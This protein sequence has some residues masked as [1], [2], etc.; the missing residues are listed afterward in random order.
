MMTMGSL[1]MFAIKKDISCK[2]ST[3]KTKSSLYKDVK[4]AKTTIFCSKDSVTNCNDLWNKLSMV[5]KLSLQRVELT[6]IS[7]SLIIYNLSI[8]YNDIHDLS[9]LA[10]LQHLQVL[11][12]E[13]NHLDDLSP[14]KD[15]SLLWLSAGDNNIEDIS[16][17][18]NSTNLHRLWL[19]GNKIR[20]ISTCTQSR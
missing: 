2:K 16:A 17:I 8:D 10:Q 1:K 5:E 13:D 3:Q 12:V 4:Q 9:P 19:G 15:L 6:N 20:D 11:W 14:L 7:G 18:A